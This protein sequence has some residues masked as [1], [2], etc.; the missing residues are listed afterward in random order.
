MISLPTPVGSRLKFAS[1]AILGLAGAATIFFVSRSH[2]RY[3]ANAASLSSPLLDAIAPAEVAREMQAAAKVPGVDGVQAAVMPHHLL[4]QLIMARLVASLRAAKPDTIV[5]VGPDHQNAGPQRFTVSSSDWRWAGKTFSQNPTVVRALARLPNV[6]VNDEVIAREHSVLVP[7]PFLHAQF[8]KARFVLLITR[9]GF[10]RQGADI[11][12]GA[13]HQV[14]GPN[15]LVIASVDFS[16]YENLASAQAEDD[17]SLA[18]LQGNNSEALGSIPADSPTS[19]A[20]AMTFARWRN[21]LRETVIDHSNSALIQGQPAAA[22][23][24]SYITMVWH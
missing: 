23:T 4:A 3:P 24:T 22:T 1:L 5:I 9:G 16:H 14:L 17:R 11:V 18:L 6:A 21:A 20:V 19:L 12:A 15:D 7:L 2:F 8:P 13:L 10:D